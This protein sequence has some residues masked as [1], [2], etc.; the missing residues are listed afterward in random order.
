MDWAWV[1]PI[2]AFIVWVIS[3][4]IRASQQ[5][6]IPPGPQRPPQARP[7]RAADAEIERFLEEINRRRQAQ[8]GRPLEERVPPR[9][10]PP[11]VQPVEAPAPKPLRPRSAA[12]RVK[13]VSQP[14]PVR[15]RPAPTLVE[16]LPTPP[17]PP[18][19]PPTPDL[20]QAAQAEAA[21]IA[22]EV[23]SLEFKPIAPVKRPEPSPLLKRLR[24]MLT[25]DGIR[26]AILVNELISPPKCLRR[27]I[28]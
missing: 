14:P 25:S 10:E 18:A 3:Q 24:E 7:Q 23:G 26:A 27:P 21:A 13:P 19:P 9:R 12:P 17:P 1:I 4:V 20:V 16:P 15:R 11:P 6:N 22:A 2:I 5:A 28:R 8:A